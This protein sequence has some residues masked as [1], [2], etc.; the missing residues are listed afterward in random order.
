M[1]CTEEVW[2]QQQITKKCETGF[3][4]LWESCWAAAWEGGVLCCGQSWLWEHGKRE[5]AVGAGPRRKPF[6]CHPSSSLLLMLCMDWESTLRSY[7][8]T[9]FGWFWSRFEAS[10]TCRETRHFHNISAAPKLE[11]DFSPSGT[12]ISICSNHNYSSPS[13]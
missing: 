3:S 12:K 8:C 4:S 5:A 11:A 6:L 10:G 7:F 9:C 13:H 1:K 2:T